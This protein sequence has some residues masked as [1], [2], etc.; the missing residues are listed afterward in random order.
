MG[1]NCT[2]HSTLQLCRSQQRKLLYHTLMMVSVMVFIDQD[3][4]LLVLMFQVKIEFQPIF[5]H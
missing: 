3:L 1:V 2:F 5:N 4:L